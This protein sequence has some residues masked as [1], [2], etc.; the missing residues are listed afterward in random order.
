MSKNYLEEFENFQKGF[1]SKSKN[2]IEEKN[3]ILNFQN[4]TYILKN[5]FCPK[6]NCER[7][8]LET[9]NKAEKEI[10]FASFVLTNDNIELLLK[11]KA[12][13]N[14]TIKGVI[15][16][17]MRNTLGSKIFKLNESF[18][19]MLDK[20]KNTMHHKFFIVDEKI[21][22]VGSA[23]PSNNGYFKNDEN[24]LIIENENLAKKFKEEFLLLFI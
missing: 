17:R 6:N 9:L 3:F 12:K 20:N 7:K 8:V 13:Q 10:L 18:E 15:E 2:E 14:L 11:E 22:I 16:N 21:L 23:N 5:Y 1:F 19:I 4:E 24:I